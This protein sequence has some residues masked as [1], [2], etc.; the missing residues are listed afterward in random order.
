MRLAVF[1]N[2]GGS[3]I[4]RF[5]V[6]L[7]SLLF[8]SEALKPEARNG[9]YSDHFMIWSH[10][11]STAVQLFRCCTFHTRKT[12]EMNRGEQDLTEEKEEENQTP[13]S[14]HQLRGRLF[15]LHM[16][17][18]NP[19]RCTRHGQDEPSLLIYPRLSFCNGI[20]P[21]CRFSL[22]PSRIKSDAYPSTVPYSL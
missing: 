22:D 15:R 10:L 13:E 19:L 7:V 17:I 3:R 18:N 1:L 11:R 5:L 12:T 16:H 2:T 4:D 14:T 20:H 21:S 9:G 8:N 6:Y